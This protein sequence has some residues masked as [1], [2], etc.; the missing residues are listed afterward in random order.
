MMAVILRLK[1]EEILTFSLSCGLVVFYKSKVS[2]SATVEFCFRKVFFS[3]EGHSFAL[4]L[5]EKLNCVGDDC[6]LLYD[7]NTIFQGVNG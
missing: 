3:S 4:S 1:I 6:K 2:P 5:V 7:F